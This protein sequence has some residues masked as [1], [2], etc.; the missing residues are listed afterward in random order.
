M[1]THNSIMMIYHS[2]ILQIHILFKIIFLL[3]LVE[4]RVMP[5]V[6]QFPA[7]KPSILTRDKKNILLSIVVNALYLV[8]EVIWYF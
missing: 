6:R 5:S 8:C 4:Y 7:L 2:F 3:N 1:L